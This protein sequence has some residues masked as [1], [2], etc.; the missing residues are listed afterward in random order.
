MAKLNK[1]LQSLL[2]DA[3]VRRLALDS[4]LSHASVLSFH[5]A[6]GNQAPH[7]VVVQPADIAPDSGDDGSAALQN[8]TMRV[9]CLTSI[10][11]DPVGMHSQE[12]GEA[13]IANLRTAAALAKI[14]AE[15]GSRYT[16][17][18][19]HI[20]VIT[21]DDSQDNEVETAVDLTCFC[22]RN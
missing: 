3:F 6:P 9:S 13:V 5:D 7:A 10:D 17:S 8:I 1:S 22:Y 14:D 12:M 2:T 21:D 16:V 11:R 19:I 18:D 4:Q 15:V 20:G